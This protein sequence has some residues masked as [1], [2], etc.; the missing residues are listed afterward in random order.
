MWFD[1]TNRLGK[2][3]S[4]GS[5]PMRFGLVVMVLS[6]VAAGSVGAVDV[7]PDA[8]SYSPFY[9]ERPEMVISEHDRSDMDSPLSYY[10]D[11]GDVATLPATVNSSQ[12]TPH[13]V[14]FDKIE[15]SAYTT[16][17]RVDGESENARTW[18]NASNYT[19]TSGGSSSM[20]V[21]DDD[22]QSPGGVET[23][24]FD[25]S[26]VDGETATAT[27]SDGVEITDDVEKRVLFAGLNVNSLSGT[28]EIRLVDS[29]GGY[30]YAEINSSANA[31]ADDVI[32]NGTADGLVFQEKVNDLAVSGSPSKIDEVQIVA[33][34]GDAD[35]ELFGLDAERKST[36]DLIE[37]SRDTDGDGDDETTTVQ[38]INGEH[39]TDG[40]V[41]T[42]SVGTLGSWADSATVHDLHVYELRYRVQDLA[43]GD[44]TSSFSEASSY[45]S[46]SDKLELTA[47]LSEPAA[48]DLSPQGSLSL[49]AD[50]ALIS[51]RYAQVRYATGTGDTALGNVSD[52]SYTDVTD[53]FTSEGETVELATGLSTGDNIV[54]D[55]TVLLTDDERRAL[56]AT[57]GAAPMGGGGG[58]FGTLLG[59]VSAIVGTVL[60]A[61][62]LKRKMGS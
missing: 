3:I 56:E 7:N 29:D 58:F 47:R 19:T 17:P 35:V 41:N 42:T 55:M 49:V 53:Q 36:I 57:G 43:D 20:S 2:T 46:Y 62:G 39:V 32:A 45:G 11:D 34:D 26:V 16:F 51:E 61:L 40:T 28:V 25:A 24:G 8:D 21:Q 10:D 54:V 12:E 6:L 37:V 4:I 18:A 1:V 52:S 9:L 22:S 48:I 27:Y 14:E 13:G 33:V 59:R 5:G 30:Y 60:G 15:T 50:Q 23:V 44:V 31:S 38:E